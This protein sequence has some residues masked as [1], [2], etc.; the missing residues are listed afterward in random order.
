MKRMTLKEYLYYL[1]LA[2]PLCT[3]E[4]RRRRAWKMHES[5]ATIPRHYE[6]QVYNELHSARKRR[7]RGK[8]LDVSRRKVYATTEKFICNRCHKVTIGGYEYP[9]LGIRLCVACKVKMRSN[10]RVHIIYTP[11]GNGR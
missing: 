5:Q 1:R 4:E 3:D 10:T 11:M 8:P 9:T 6:I 7:K 2:Y